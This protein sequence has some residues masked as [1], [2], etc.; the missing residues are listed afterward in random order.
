MNNPVRWRVPFLLVV[1]A[2]L[3]AQRT[4]A[5]QN[6]YAGVVTDRDGAPIEEAGVVTSGKGF[7]GWAMSKADGSFQLPGFGAFVSFRHGN[8]KPKLIRSRDLPAPLR[9]RLDPLDESVGKLRECEEKSGEEWVGQGLRVRVKGKY[10]GPVHGE[11]DAHWY[12]RNKGD[13]LNVVSGYAWH[14]GLPHEQKLVETKDIAVRGWFFEKVVGLD[15]SGRDSKGN[16]W[17]WVG[18]PVS[19]AI[20]YEASTKETAA[21]FDRI[22]STM[23]FQPYRAKP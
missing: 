12:I 6:E 22:I 16:Y 15:L 4:G 1:A 14:A 3:L 8:F 20:E 9:V 17:R 2:A 18:A 11:H 13:L 10:E 19:D 23:C 21:S 5:Q 7:K